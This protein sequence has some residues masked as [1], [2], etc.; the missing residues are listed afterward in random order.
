MYNQTEAILSQYEI[1]IKDVTKGRG[2][3]ICETDRGK[4]ILVP[5][6]ASKE[7]GMLICRFLSKLQENFY[8]EQIELN[9]NKE[10][11]TED[12]FSG[13][14]FLLKTYVE[15]N[16]I[17]TNRM[18]EIKGAAGLLA[19]YHNAT[20]NLDMEMEQLARTEDVLMLWRRHYQELIKVRN[21]IRNRKKKNEFEQIYMQH[22]EH[23]RMSAQAALE[24]LEEQTMKQTRCVVCHGDVNQHNILLWNGTYRL[25]HFEN[26]VYNWGMIDLATFLRKMLEKNNWDEKVGRALICEYDAHRPIQKEEYEQ[27]Y[28]LL[29]FPEKLWKVANHYIN[30]RKTWMSGRDAEKIKKVMEQEEKR[31]IFLQNV[32]AFLK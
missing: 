30:S 11:V 1:E 28:A 9:K 2:T 24:R 7:K 12:E 25:V 3:Y 20:E 16:E 29:L 17:G 19:Q 27:L 8:A 26:V 18:E 23:N 21:Y 10:A 22:F 31:L 5:F 15:G 13:E 4:K 32:F 14:R 6:S